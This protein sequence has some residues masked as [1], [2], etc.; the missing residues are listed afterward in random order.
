[1]LIHEFTND[2]GDLTSRVSIRGKSYM[3]VLR[4][5]E[6]DCCVGSARLFRTESSAVAYAKECVAS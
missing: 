6:A 1:M 2:E 3:V 4:D 5:N